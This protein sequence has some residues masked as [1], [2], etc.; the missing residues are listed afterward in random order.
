MEIILA[1]IG[2]LVLIFV[3]I[4]LVY[5]AGMK[6]IHIAHERA[7]ADIDNGNDGWMR[8]Y[9]EIEGDNKWM[10]FDIR[11]WTFTQFYPDL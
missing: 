11:K 7:I 5:R 8:H 3:R 9:R 1:V 2:L 6:A 4:E 10:L